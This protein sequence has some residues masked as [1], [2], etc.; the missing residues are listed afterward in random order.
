MTREEALKI[1]EKHW[2][3]CD[4]NESIIA[5]VIDAGT[6]YVAPTRMPVAWRR[7]SEI[8]A[9]GWMY[10]SCA[11]RPPGEGWQPLYAD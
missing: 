5:A 10:D 4:G 9:C 7:R 6:A 2:N 8:H 11:S 1:I 3:P